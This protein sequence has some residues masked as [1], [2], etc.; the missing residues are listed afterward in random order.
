MGMS[1][2]K[3]L[4]PYQNGALLTMVLMELHHGLEGKITDDITVED[5]EWVCSLR[6]Q[7]S[8]Q[9]QGPSWRKGQ[10]TNLLGVLKSP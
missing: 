7:V 3:D 8:G 9:C 2:K 4:V 6:E 5:E 1:K 10:V